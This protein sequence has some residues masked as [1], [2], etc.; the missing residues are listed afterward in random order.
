MK[1]RMHFFTAPFRLE[2]GCTRKGR[3][4]YRWTTGYQAALANGQTSQAVTRAGAY[5]MAKQSG[6][7]AK[8]HPSE[9]SAR[10]AV[11]S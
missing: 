2:V 7:T 1:F 9:D 6:R 10:A 4:S 11:Q 3:P 8:F 5:H